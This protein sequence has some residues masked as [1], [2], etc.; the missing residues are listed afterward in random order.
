MAEA[1]EREKKK[2]D[3]R[4]TLIFKKETTPLGRHDI[5]WSELEEPIP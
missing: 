1:E 5:R 3:L 4:R 2:N